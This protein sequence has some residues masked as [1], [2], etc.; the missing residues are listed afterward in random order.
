MVYHQEYIEMRIIK[1]SNLN[2]YA[3]KYAIRLRKEGIMNI[4]EQLEFFKNNTVVN[5]HEHVWMNAEGNMNEQEYDTLMEHAELVGMDTMVISCPITSSGHE[6]VEAMQHVNNIV[7]DACKKYPNR[8]KGYVFVDPVHGKAA[9][10]EIQ[11]C[12]DLG[13]VGVK[14]YH[15]YHINDAM[16][17]PIIEKCIDLKIPILMHAGK[18]NQ[19]PETQKNISDSTHF[20]AAAKKYPEAVFIM[21]HISGGGDW[22]WQLKGMAECKNVF[23]DISGSVHDDPLIEET[24]AVMGADRILFG[25]DGSFSACIGK[26]LGARITHQEKLTI[27]NNPHFVKYLRS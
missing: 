13:M 6:S 20:I 4:K 19:Y 5:W 11:R 18:L 26:I 17:Y 25:T 15:Q 10:E 22:H 14:M 2:L 21:A 3:K 27:M 23:T 24:V 16:Q 8:A 12:Y 7:L 9:V 1:I